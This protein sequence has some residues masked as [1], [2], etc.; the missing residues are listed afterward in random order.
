MDKRSTLAFLL[1]GLITFIWVMRMQ[2]RHRRQ[3]EAA[4]IQQQQV[5]TGDESGSGG[6]PS[7]PIPETPPSVTDRKTSLVPKTDVALQDNILISRENLKYE[8]I[9]TNRGAALR[10]ARLTDFAEELESKT[11][12]LLLEEVPEQIATFALRDPNH[13]YPFNTQNYEF[14]RKDDGR[15]VFT[16]VFDDALRVTKEFIPRPGKNELG[17]KITFANESKEGKSLYARYEIVAAARLV[18][19]GSATSMLTAPCGYKKDNGNVAVELGVPRRGKSWWPFGNK[20]RM[21]YFRQSNKSEKILWAGGSNRYFAAILRAEDS[22]NTPAEDVIFSAR[23]DLLESVDQTRSA[24]GSV[25]QTDNLYAIL[26]PN[27]KELNPGESVTHNYAYF[28]GPKKPEILADYPDMAKILDY[29]MFGAVSRVLLW[30]LGFFYRIIPNYGASIILLTIVVKVCLHPF[31]RKSQISMH[32]MQKLQ[33]LIRELQEKHKGDRQKLGQAQMELMRKHGANPMGGCWPMLFQIP[34]FF[35]LFRMLQ[36]SVQLRHAGFVLWI[37]D[38]A[39]PDTITHISS[40]P[41]NILPVLMVISWFA[42]QLT[43]PKPADPQQAQTQKMMLFM[44]IM[45]GIMLYGMASGLTLYWL[46][47]TFLGILEQKWIKRQIAKLDAEGA[48]AAEDAE[49]A[50]AQPKRQRRK[51]KK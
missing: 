21:P 12:V 10:R 49:V 6:K 25:R 13:T 44:P 39:R 33:P 48:F 20:R 31:T 42:Q 50:H 5:T 23:M 18:P 16:S 34:V 15:I 14:E 2:Q 4:P 45:F 32:K 40:F 19:E 28:M 46:T 43:Q 3:R 36:Y 24:R 37:K 27:P 38:L 7:Q 1:I 41:I 29:G 30:V 17:V 9:W 11:G 8:L 35:G 47:S 51:R 26:S 22:G